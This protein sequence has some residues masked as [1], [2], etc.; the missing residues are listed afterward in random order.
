MTTHSD[1]TYVE[2][3]VVH[4]CVGNMPGAVP[5]TSTPGAD[6]RHP[7]RTSSHSPTWG[8]TEA[9]RAD[10]GA[11]P[12]RQR[13]RG[14]GHQ[15]AGGRGHGQPLLPAREPPALRVR[16]G[17]GVPGAHAR[18]HAAVR[19]RGVR[20]LAASWSGVWPTRRWRRTGATCCSWSSTCAEA[21]HDLERRDAEDSAGLPRRARRGDRRPGPARWPPSGRSTG[22]SCCTGRIDARP[23]RPAWPRRA[24]TAPAHGALRGRGGATAHA[25]AGHAAGSARP[26]AARGALRGGA[27]GLGG[28]RPAAAGRGPRGRASCAPSARATRSGWCRWAGRAWRPSR[29]TC[30][31]GGRCWAAPGGL[32]AAGA[33]PQRPRAA[34]VAPGAA[35]DREEVR[36]RGRPA[37][38]R[39][40]PHAAPLLRHPP[41]GGRG[42]S[43]GGAGDA[44]PRRPLHHPDLHASDAE[45]PAPGLRRRPSP[46]RAWRT[47]GREPLR[48]PGP[49][50]RGGG[51]AA[52]RGRLRRRGRRTRW[53][54]S[55]AWSTSAC[56]TWPP[57][58]WATSCPCAA[59]RP[60]RRRRWLCPGGW[61]SAPRART[62]PTGHWEH[63]GVVTEPALPHLPGRLPRGGARR[64][65]ASASAATCWAT[66]PPRAPRSS[67]SWAR[68]TCAPGDP[69]STRRPT[70]SSRSPATSTSCPLEELYRWCAVAREHPDRPPR[71]RPGDR[72]AVR[73]ARPG[74]SCAPRTARTSRWSPPGTTYLDLLGG[75]GRPGDR[76]G[77]DLADLRRSGR[78]R[79]EQ[80]GLQRRQPGAGWPSSW[81]RDGTACSSPTWWTSTWPGGT[82]TTSTAS[83]RG[84]AAVDR[85]PARLLAAAGPRRPSAHDGRPRG[86]PHH[87]GHRP[88][89]RVRAPAATTRDRRSA[90]GLLRGDDGRH[91]G[92]RLRP[93]RRRGAAPGR[94]GYRSPDPAAGMASPT[95]RW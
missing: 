27:A 30:S 38:R 13:D 41:A 17:T 92:H 8:W 62:P 51:R 77:Q 84:L 58:V 9:A 23:A 87:G 67:P 79:G 49:G 74:A 47:T 85:G 56:R 25:A 53:A 95:R 75:A 43:A 7:A 4:Y 48:L 71:R 81:S 37:R 5:I 57:S 24:P 44:G 52:R 86:R 11:G 59:C 15:R 32:Q 76:R 33:L 60:R 40:G 12:G 83:P 6:E 78:L 16:L 66:S 54:T 28:A 34:A 42:R 45:P 39:V 31:E 46:G 82:A 20:D 70:A 18:S 26:G 55:P 19:R 21:G 1:P 50:R 89:P 2:H 68:S 22:T 72:P 73:R 65:S 10:A 88:H 91:R 3:G 61:P 29:P 36:P 35:P 69:S 64:P 93:T 90:A 14:K 80:G 63:M 94:P